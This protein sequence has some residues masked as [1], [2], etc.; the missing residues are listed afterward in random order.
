MPVVLLGEGVPRYVAEGVERFGYRLV[1][2]KG[3]ALELKAEVA[4]ELRAM[5]DMHIA[6]FAAVFWGHPDTSFSLHC[7]ARRRYLLEGCTGLGWEGRS[8]V[9]WKGDF[10]IPR[11]GDGMEWPFGRLK[12][13][14]EGGK[15]SPAVS[16][17]FCEAALEMLGVGEDVDM[18][19]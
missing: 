6:L 19:R 16:R 4:P 17:E 11:G 13:Y 5:I 7:L 18:G 12:R 8:G 2:L 15:G 14:G 1:G 10:L 9:D 3:R